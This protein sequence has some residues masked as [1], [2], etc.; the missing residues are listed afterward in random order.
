MIQNDL[1][2]VVPLGVSSP[3]TPVKKYLLE[4]INSL[5]NQ[6]TKFSYDIV[7][8]CDDNV[9]NEIKEV[10]LN[11][12]FMIEWFEPYCFMRKG[13]IW[14]K[15]HTV[16]KNT[17]SKYIAFCHYDDVW[18]ENKIQSQIEFMISNNLEISWSQVRTINE[19]NQI[20]SNDLCHFESLNANT[21][22]ASSYAFC[23]SSIIDKNA[24]LNSGILDYVDNG[25]GIYE[26][27]QFIFSH[28]L[29]GKKDNNSC[30]FHRVHT[31]SVTNNFN[32][33]KLYMTEQRRQANY[34]LQQVLEDANNI[35][36]DKIIKSILHENNLP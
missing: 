3:N 9:T 8:A 5:K 31:N 14:K 1:C 30:F 11:S 10:L 27:L 26:K 35:P 29:N 19:N 21:I 33:E 23:H 16:W 20:Y 15:I 22:N 36:L 24:F 12:G 7:F 34:S 6:K 4:C 2:I 32:F 13:G 17:N 25:S 18:S 28:K